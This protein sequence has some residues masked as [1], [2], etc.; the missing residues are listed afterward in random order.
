MARLTGKV[1]FVT[2]AARGQG[3]SHALRLAAEGADIIAVDICTDIGSV[4]Y[5]LGSSAELAET[6]QLVEKLDRRIV[7]RQA[8][9]RDYATLESVLAEGVAELGRLD[10]VVANAGILSYGPASELST[11]TWQDMIDVNLT[12]VYHTAR[13]GIPH[14]RAGGNGGSIVLTSSILGIRAMPNVAHYVAAKAGVI[15]LMRSLALEL[16]PHSIRVN[17]VNPSIVDTDMVH[18]PS[19]Y[20]LFVPHIPNPSREQAAEVFASMNALPTPWAQSEDVSNA[21]AFLASDESRF[22]TGQEF[23]IDSGFALG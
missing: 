8:D 6:A 1:A 18:N 2:G 7:A 22:V 5:P 14:L 17:T 20:S 4:D 16:G 3:R 15:G 12:G 10:V 21:V 13:A 9:V 11:T 19:T 23:K